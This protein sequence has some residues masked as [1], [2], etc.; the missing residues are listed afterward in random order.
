MPRAS[1][2]FLRTPSSPS[3]VRWSS[4]A[5]R[6]GAARRGWRAAA[7]RGRVAARGAAG[8]QGA[9]SFSWVRNVCW[10]PGSI[11]FGKRTR[12][13]TTRR[14]RWGWRGGAHPGSVN[15]RYGAT[16]AVGVLVRGGGSSRVGGRAS[17]WRSGEETQGRGRYS[18]QEE[19]LES[20]AHAGPAWGESTALTSV[21]APGT[22]PHLLHLAPSFPLA[23]N[24]QAPSSA[25]RA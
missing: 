25:D 17:T 24:I 12:A 9:R 8:D 11:R 7:E 18:G 1:V 2:R 16:Q 22:P 13:G 21:S 19:R 6:R 5:R 3:G 10:L 4:G 20:D 23:T 15:Y 14:G